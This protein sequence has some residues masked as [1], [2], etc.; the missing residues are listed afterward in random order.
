MIKDVN[1]LILDS[2]AYDRSGHYLDFRDAVIK[3][4]NEKFVVNR[5]CISVTELSTA[6]ESAKLEDN[7]HIFILWED[8]W[9]LSDLEHIAQVSVGRR[10]RIS[11]VVNPIQDLE[12]KGLPIPSCKYYYSKIFFEK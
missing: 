2:S 11:I 8:D 12:K 1:V 3:I 10:V 4:L 5:L 9:S 7:F 6:F